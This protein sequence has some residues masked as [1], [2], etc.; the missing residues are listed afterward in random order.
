MAIRLDRE[1]FGVT[2]RM[3]AW[4]KIFSNEMWP[5][6]GFGDRPIGNPALDRDA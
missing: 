4:R 6:M 3:R 1:T 5:A 2:E